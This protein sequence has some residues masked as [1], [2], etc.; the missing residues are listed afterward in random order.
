MR[1]F[2]IV[3]PIGRNGL[4][5]LKEKIDARD[6]PVP[7]EARACLLMRFAQ[8]DLINNQICEWDRP[9]IASA[10]VDGMATLFPNLV[11]P[12]RRLPQGVLEAM[13]LVMRNAGQGDH[14]GVHARLLK[15]RDARIGGRERGDLIV[16]GVNGENRNLPPGG[17]L[18]RAAG[19]WNRRAENLREF[20]RKMP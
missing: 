5:T 2:G 1:E 7:E 12:W 13:C 11:Q 4:H 14:P 15:L 6:A 8:L 18:R 9:I 3:A 10:A 16:A 17:R 19:D 20:L